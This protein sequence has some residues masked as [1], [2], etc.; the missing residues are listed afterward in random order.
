MAAVGEM[1]VTLTFDEPFEANR[2]ITALSNQ[3][4]KMQSIYDQ[5]ADASRIAL[6]EMAVLKADLEALVALR[7]GDE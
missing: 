2:R 7:P 3:I 6:N 1:T 5:L 4:A